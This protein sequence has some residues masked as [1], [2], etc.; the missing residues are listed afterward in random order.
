MGDWTSSIF[1]IS[2]AIMLFG[3]LSLA[4]TFFIKDRRWILALVLVFMLC[5]VVGFGM[6]G[7]WIGLGMYVILSIRSV[8]D[9]LVGKKRTQEDKKRITKTDCIMLGIWSI[10][11]IVVAVVAEI[12]APD[13]FLAWFAFFATFT[14]LIS[15]W[16]KNIK[17]YRW[18]AV[19]VSILWIVYNAHVENV[20]GV[21]MR[22]GLLGLGIVGVIMLYTHK[23]ARI[24]VSESIQTKIVD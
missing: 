23:K 15:I 21:I 18:M 11:L 2:Q 20:V 14:F 8:V 22:T 4:V 17:V 7:A 19:M 3:F 10:L 6:L 12:V 1:I 24:L 9:Y 13:G 16:Q 5:L